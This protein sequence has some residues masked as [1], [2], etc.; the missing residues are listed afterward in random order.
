MKNYAGEGKLGGWVVVA[1]SSPDFTC[2]LPSHAMQKAAC[3]LNTQE[4]L[5]PEKTGNSEKR[6]KVMYTYARVCEILFNI[7]ILKE[8]GSFFR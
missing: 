2:Q 6:E 8:G 4:H 3:Q 1:D 7:E 5:T